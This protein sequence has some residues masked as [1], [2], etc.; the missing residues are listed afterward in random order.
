MKKKNKKQNLKK[1]NQSGNN[2]F[3]TFEHSQKMNQNS[4]KYFFATLLNSFTRS[5]VSKKFLVV[6]A[7]LFFFLNQVYV[8]L[9]VMITGDSP[10][11]QGQSLVPHFEEPKAYAADPEA[12]PQTV[13]VTSNTQKYI[14][15]EG[16]D[17]NGMSSFGDHDGTN[18]NPL[19]YH[20]PQ[21]TPN[22]GT[23]TG[24]G[25]ILTYIP[26][27]NY[28]GG[29]SFTFTVSD[30]ALTSAP[31][32][33][34]I[35]VKPP[36]MPIGIP[37]TDT[38][39]NPLFGIH[40]TVASIYGS[41]NYYTHFIHNDNS[42]T[43]HD[44]PTYIQNRAFEDAANWQGIDG[45]NVAIVRDPFDTVPPD[46]PENHHPH[47][48]RMRSDSSGVYSV[49]QIM[50]GNIVNEQLFS[51][52]V[53]VYYSQV[54]GIEIK[55]DWLSS[56]NAVIRSDTLY[57]IGSMQS[58]SQ[59][60]SNVSYFPGGSNVNAP[61]GFTSVRMTLSAQ[62]AG[63]PNS[64]VYF[65]NADLARRGDTNAP[66]CTFSELLPQ[67]SVAEVYDF[68]AGP[69]ETTIAVGGTLQ[70][71]V[72][73]RGHNLSQKPF[74][75]VH[76]RIS[77]EYL[78][79]ENL[80]FGDRDGD[81]SG[82]IAGIVDFINNA[83]HHIVFRHNDMHGNIGEGGIRAGGT[84]NFIWDNVIHDGGDW[85]LGALGHPCCD[86]G[87]DPFVIIEHGAPDD[88]MACPSNPPLFDCDQDVHGISTNDGLNH[89]WVIDNEFYH[90][91]G[92]GMQTSGNTNDPAN[93]LLVHHVYFG[94]NRGYY[95]K[96]SAFG[97]KVAND[98]II[99][100]NQMHSHRPSDSSPGL[101]SGTQYG[102]RNLWYLFN[103]MWDASLGVQ[104]AAT[105]GNNQDGQY[106]IGNVFY[107]LHD[108][109]NPDP[110]HA[111][112]PGQCLV[113]WGYG[114]RYFVN[115]TV[116]DTDGG[117]SW[118]NPQPAYIVNNIF[119]SLRPGF[120]QVTVE[121]NNA[122]YHDSIFMNNLIDG[123][124]RMKWG[125][126]NIY[127][128]IPS[129][130]AA[131]GQGQGCLI[132]SANFMSPTNADFHL[133]STSAAK[134][135]GTA[136]TVPYDIF[137]ALYGIDIKV[138]HDGNPRPSGSAWDMGAYEYRENVPCN[139]VVDCENRPCTDEACVN[140]LCQW[141]PRC[142][143]PG[144]MCVNDQCVPDTTPPNITNI[145]VSN[146]TTSTA[147]VT[148]TTD[149]LSTSFVDY[150]TSASYG[151]TAGN[152]AYVTSHSVPL[153]NLTSGTTYHFK[154]RS[155][156]A[157]QNESNGP[158]PIDHTF[159]TVNPA[160]CD[161][162]SG[163]Y[164]AQPGENSIT[165]EGEDYCDLI[166]PPPLGDVNNDYWDIT[167]ASGAVGNSAVQAVDGGPHFGA[168]NSN[169]DTGAGFT[170]RFRPAISGPYLVA[171]RVQTL[172]GTSDS[173]HIGLNGVYREMIDWQTPTATSWTWARPNGTTPVVNIGMLNADQDYI[174][175]VVIRENQIRIDRFFI[176]LQG[177]ATFPGGNAAGP[178]ES[179]LDNPSQNQPPTVSAG[180]NQ[181]ITL[182][183]SSVILN[184]SVQDDG[185]PNPPGNVT[186]SW[187]Q[188]N[189]PVVANIQSSNSAVTN[190]TGLLQPGDYGFML[191]GD[192][193][194]NGP[195][196]PVTSTVMIHVNAG[197]GI[198]QNDR[199]CTDGL[200]CN[201]EETCQNGH[202]TAGILPCGQAGACNEASDHCL[203]GCNQN[204]FSC[205]DD[206][207]CN[208]RPYCS[209]AEGICRPGIPIN[210][211]D[212]NA[213]TVDSCDPTMGCQHQ[214]SCIAND[215]PAKRFSKNH[216]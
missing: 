161:N 99:S 43:C 124:F 89:I 76:M 203:V 169:F 6:L 28:E 211:D 107:D 17:I 166:H 120:N 170:L 45:T 209:Y 56:S 144:D 176:G 34:T 8:P 14:V 100:Q 179:S 105:N 73:I 154:V 3:L 68:Y 63:G 96:Q 106:Y 9:P 152:G 103:E 216:R 59:Q 41:N 47:A 88:G 111:N 164:F 22:S 126:N 62:V 70:N 18:S 122:S 50:S 181:N 33:I 159:S 12:V 165:I 23:L 82:G 194:G 74:I 95:N 185:L 42:A 177:Q 127:T 180:Q 11:N 84:N 16:K 94:R 26:P 61:A 184:G 199:D 168:V 175:N 101:N 125:G 208:S 118:E 174:L 143:N 147:T 115:N 54:Y 67:G 98:I 119:A 207:H 81:L 163:T 130:Q 178:S 202:C 108:T 135:A 131:T 132:G 134:D 37:D 57:S 171:A 114:S 53:A 30:G 20:F 60:Y 206:N 19:V 186:I 195:N 90:L 167:N 25:P 85:Q 65:N 48:L 151:A 183:T 97:C 55:L 157:A 150:G 93:P 52:G 7:A 27:P 198:C 182:P 2:F 142:T 109:G 123:T 172:G 214:N 193:D 133:Q 192:D 80:E 31:A 46:E 200:F 155:V 187:T 72:F 75:A 35:N 160:H 197:N 210:C 121:E 138:D 51:G 213:C 212:G 140:H 92:D 158:N 15:L 113:A 215:P 112:H 189:G 66:R 204:P 78:I 139:G 77:G 156:D 148:W 36:Q 137:Q 21:T 136:Y 13:R 149:E 29:D 39:N 191:S 10:Q 116:Y 24:T 87:V 146:I 69:V 141:T 38:A 49:S 58:Q 64:F 145:Q 162:Q 201:G 86:H 196:T 91:S 128:S 4:K 188:T 190:V 40:E 32:T 129:F 5:K 83:N 79:L 117:L 1:K 104:A 173:V 153:N 110:D 71:P 205:Y 102:A 44:S